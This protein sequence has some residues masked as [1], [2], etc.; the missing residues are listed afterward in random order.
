[1]HERFDAGV[2]TIDDRRG[3]QPPRATSH[4]EQQLVKRR[5][6]ERIRGQARVRLTDRAVGL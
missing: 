6:G 5:D 1:M 2:M 4:A 3:E